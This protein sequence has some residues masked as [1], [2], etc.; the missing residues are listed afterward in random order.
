MES[1]RS[2]IYS[3]DL[4]IKQH[5]DLMICVQDP[6]TI[7]ETRLLRLAIAQIEDSDTQLHPYT[8][9]V[10]KIA[11]WLNITNSNIYRQDLPGLAESILT[12]CIYLPVKNSNNENAEQPIPW[13]ESINC[14]K[15]IIQLKLNDALKPYLIFA[16]LKAQRSYKSEILA[17]LPNASTIR[18]YELLLSGMSEKAGSGGEVNHTISF[19]IAQLH[20]HF[21]CTGKYK[22]TGNFIRMFIQ[23]AVNHINAKTT[24]HICYKAIKTGKR[25]EAIEF[26]ICEKMI[27]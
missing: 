24:M 16:D 9:E 8:F 23:R 27:E 14:K 21:G 20:K 19:T 2:I 10:V 3:N 25:Y 7:F 6:L 22:N 17:T 1:P 26:S 18:F 5:R 4:I 12:K 13:I 15:G 11:Q